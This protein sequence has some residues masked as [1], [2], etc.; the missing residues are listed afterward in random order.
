MISGA[1]KI[2]LVLILAAAG[3]FFIMFGPPKLMARTETPDFCVSCHVMESQY[4]AWFHTGAHRSIKCIDCHLPHDNIGNYYTWKSIDGMKD[5]FIFYS[6]NVPETITISSHGERT[7][8][9]NCN[10]CHEAAVE[11][12]DNSRNCW[13]CHRW[14]RHKL[15]GTRLTNQ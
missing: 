1:K 14:L 12:I 8:L 2:I 10:R 13:D 15:A 5:M 6:G 11:K 9:S 4:E 3:G 7:V